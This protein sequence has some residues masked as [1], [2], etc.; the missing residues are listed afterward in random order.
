[1][2]PVQLLVVI[3]EALIEQLQYLSILHS[4]QVNGSYHV[5]SWHMSGIVYVG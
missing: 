4:F 5:Y 3:I 2:K 1:M